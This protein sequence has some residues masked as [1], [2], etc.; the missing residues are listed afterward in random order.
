MDDILY[1]IYDKKGDWDA[2]IV[3]SGD[4]MV[5]VGKSM[6]AQQIGY[7]FAHSCGTPFGIENIHFNGEDL[8]KFSEKNANTPF[9]VHVYDEAKKTLDSKKVMT[10][11]T[12]NLETFFL[13][14]GQYNHIFI[15]VTPDF[16]TLPD[17]FAISRSECL[18]NVFRKEEINKRIDK[19]DWVRGNFEYFSRTRKKN[20]YHIGKKQN[21]NYF[22]VKPNFYGEYRKFWVIDDDEYMKKKS[23]AAKMA[24]D[25]KDKV[26]VM[27]ERYIVNMKKL[28][29]NDT[30][31]AEYLGLTQQRVQQIVSE[32]KKNDLIAKS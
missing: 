13:E 27:R 29:L 15:L 31:I 28:G 6:I 3:I 14:C 21:K 5:R 24:V 25:D 23:E 11:I 26:M 22:A 2:V 17:M 30:R 16:F 9:V 7:Y 12:Q 18:L 32:L 8:R 4:G 1:N 20:L 19:C 10:K